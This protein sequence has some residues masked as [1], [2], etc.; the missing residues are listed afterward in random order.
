VSPYLQ[1]NAA[2]RSA[3]V[4][5]IVAPLFW[6]VTVTLDK[7]VAAFIVNDNVGGGPGVCVGTTAMGVGV[8]VVLGFFGAAEFA[9]AA[10]PMMVINA[11]TPTIR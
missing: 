3:A 1:L 6:L 4:N 7:P 9:T 2:G 11:I 5:V 10:I 8:G